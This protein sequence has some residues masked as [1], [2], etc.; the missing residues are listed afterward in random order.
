MDEVEKFMDDDDFEDAYTSV[1]AD[2]GKKCTIF[3]IDASPKMFE[4]YENDDSHDDC[5]FRR[6][7]KIVRLQMIN[8]AVTSTSGEHTCCILLN[9]QNKSHSVDHIYILQEVEEISADRIKEL[10]KLL[11]S[12]NILSAFKDICGE[13][14]CCDY[15]EALFLC[16]KRVTCR[17]PYFRKR[18][19]YLFTNE[20]NPFGTNNQHRISAC[21]NAD[22]LR[23]HN[24]EFSV[25]PLVAE[26]DT[27]TFS[28]LEQLDPDVEK[29]FENISELEKEI[30]KKQYAHR[31]IAGMDFE[32]GNG[33]KISVGIYSLLRSEK[34]PQ[35][36]ILNAET[37]E[38]MQ[39]SHIYVNKEADEE[40]PVLDKE[41]IRKRQIGGEVISL[42]A[43]EIENLRRL[44]PP[45]ILLLGFKPLS[46]IKITH[47]VRSSQFVY[48]LEKDILGS[49][50]L[51][52]ILYEVC[53]KQKKMIICRY[54][55]K[56]NVPPKLVALVPQTSVTDDNSKDKL[57]SK[58]CYPGF[59]LV[60]LPFAED[61]R[62]LS[63]Q[64]THRDG[65]WPTA[66]KEQIET[67]RKLVKKLT[68]SYYPEKFCNPVLQKHYKVIEALALDY[69]EVPEVQDQIQPYF[70]YDDFR[71][72]VEKE[73]DEFR[74]SL[75][76][77]GCNS[78]QKCTKEAKKAGKI[79]STW[80]TKKKLV[81]ESLLYLANNHLLEKMTVAQ[82]KKKAEE[83]LIPLKSNAK[84]ADI[85]GA[86]DQHYRDI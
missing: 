66:S 82:L 39:R 8:K 44:T 11:K 46:C 17:T 73:L 34:I 38:I 22:D 18:T 81:D 6:A 14:G 68:T 30:P 32:L 57:S 25:Y 50:R 79:S 85:I 26:N 37:N 55:Q 77:D 51:Y 20:M 28:I 63:E 16:I 62:D 80:N 86:I 13:H 45:G 12:E 48:P 36:A 60:Y 10:D 23:N 5:A 1:L 3:L 59:H 29:N 78:E 75:F 24:T 53:M 84:K 70:V 74:S 15:S 31:N 19:V 58:F 4:K 52:R 61:K 27:F 65:E 42:S 40:V 76:L 33:L 54:T 9:T 43:D 56:A 47:H 71:K 35:P 64:M 2:G 49:I 67:A 69:D 41:I 21:K 7:L 83:E 72:R